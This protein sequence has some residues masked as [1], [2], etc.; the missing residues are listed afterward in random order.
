M[1]YKSGALLVLA[2]LNILTYKILDI[3]RFIADSFQLC[4]YISIRLPVQLQFDLNRILLII[5]CCSP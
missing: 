3:T 5:L 2:P 1:F 4:Q